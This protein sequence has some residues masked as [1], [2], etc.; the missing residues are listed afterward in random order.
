MTHQID[1]CIVYLRI[2]CIH[3]YMNIKKCIYPW[4]KQNICI[5][6]YGNS[7]YGNKVAV[8]LNKFLRQISNVS[9]LFHKIQNLM[10]AW[11]AKSPIVLPWSANA[12]RQKFNFFHSSNMKHYV[13]SLTIGWEGSLVISLWSGQWPTQS[14]SHG[15]AFLGRSL[16]MEPWLYL[17]LAMVP[18]PASIRYAMALMIIMDPIAMPALVW[19][20]SRTSL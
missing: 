14:I 16:R 17:R 7:K 19:S 9:L 2:T 12:T 18:V 5:S 10:L 15:G 13:W 11:Y 1:K 20:L 6:K 4:I 3:T 8:T